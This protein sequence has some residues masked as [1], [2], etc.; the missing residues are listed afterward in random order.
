MLVSKLTAANVVIQSLL[1]IESAA[2]PSSSAAESSS[3]SAVAAG[4][5]QP[6]TAPKD[7]FYSPAVEQLIALRGEI[8]TD[9]FERAK[10]RLQ[11]LRDT[12]ES[13]EANMRDREHVYN[14]YQHAKDVVLNLSQF[15]G[16]RPL[17]AIKYSPNGH[18]VATGSFGAE[19]K[20]WEANTLGPRYTYFGHS[21]RVTSVAW[22][23]CSAGNSDHPVFAS[24]S[25]DG[26]V[27]V[28][29]GRRFVG[30]EAQTDGRPVQQVAASSSSMD[31]DGDDDPASSREEAA[32]NQF[33]AS[34]LQSRIPSYHHKV[35]VSDSGAV[36]SSC[37]FHPHFPQLLAVS[38]HDYSWRLYD[39]DHA[40]KRSE[41][42]SMTELLL[43]DGHT[44]E[45]SALAFHPDGSLVMTGDASGVAM[46]W[47]IRSG[48]M[49][50][51]FPGHVKKISSIS[52]HAQGFQVLTGSVDNT[53]KVWDLRKRKCCYTIP[54]HSNLIA[55]ST[56][57]SSGELICTASFD[58][59][60]K[61]FGSRDFRHI[62]T[63]AGHNGKVMACDMSPDEKHV[64]SAGYDRTIKLWAHK[65]EF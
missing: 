6:A 9:S 47:D 64:V 52:F 42:S 39:V 8:A 63:L 5:K 1:G 16:D 54:A 21:D 28:W 46:L 3:S 24:T 22:Q 58:G 55:D 44:K 4:T 57:S 23:S 15:G 60:L 10:L 36:V 50:Q 43:Q 38:C 2:A 53:V 61:L 65:S 62:R 7:V 49:I 19:I 56:Y 26:H 34:V 45:A 30:S 17:S 48:Q 40:A 27:I 25:A 29:D 41:Q 11:R 20:V 14:L 18:F 13:A 33:V 12:V 32:N 51:G 31:V 35:K 59:T 37:A